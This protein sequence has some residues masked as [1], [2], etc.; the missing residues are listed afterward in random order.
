MWRLN[1]VV[2][3][4]VVINSLSSKRVDMKQ[5]ANYNYSQWEWKLDFCLWK[6]QQEN[7]IKQVFLWV[8]KWRGFVRY[9]LPATDCLAVILI[10]FCGSFTY[11]LCLK[12]KEEIACQFVAYLN[13][14]KAPV[15][16]SL[17]YFP[18]LFKA[19]KSAYNSDARWDISYSPTYATNKAIFRSASSAIIFYN[20]NLTSYVN[21]LKCFSFFG[22][23]KCETAIYGW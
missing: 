12:E 8:T 1:W 7:C 23:S 14:F 6:E 11:G 17:K 15:N 4:Y 10:F 18:T 19:F 2:L 21:L 22:R 5:H 9:T 13:F 16:D 3:L 20:S